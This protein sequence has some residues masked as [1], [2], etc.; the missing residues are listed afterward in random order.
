MKPLLVVFVFLFLWDP[1]LA[2]MHK[3]C[4]KNGI[5]RLECYE[6]EMLV[7]YCMFQLECCVK[8]NPAP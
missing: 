7:A 6:S 8:G 2:E 1:V 4:Y 3:K 5:C